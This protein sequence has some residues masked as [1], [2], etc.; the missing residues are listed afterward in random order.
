[1][2]GVVAVRERWSH[3]VVQRWCWQ[4]LRADATCPS[5]PRHLVSPEHF[6]VEFVG[7]SLGQE[8]VPPRFGVRRK[9][10]LDADQPTEHLPARRT[11]GLEHVEAEEDQEVP[12]LLREGLAALF[13]KELPLPPPA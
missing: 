12:E 6:S 9:Q 1:M 11:E 7:S 3:R 8:H 5:Q 2:Y 10:G 4:W 13:D